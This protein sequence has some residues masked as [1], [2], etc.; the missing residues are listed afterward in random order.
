MSEVRTAR[1]TMWVRHFGTPA[2]AVVALHG[3]T[4]NGDMFADFAGRMVA[5]VAAP[6]LP[7]HGRTAIEPV[8]IGNAVDAIAEVLRGA[9]S[10][11]L[12]LGYSQGGRIALQTALIYP[13]LIGS[14]LL[15]STSPG[16]PERSRRLRRAADEGLADRIEKIGV[17]RFIDEWLANPVTSTSGVDAETRRKDRTTRL[18]NTA[19]GLAAAL[20]GMGQGCVADTSE[21]IPSLTMPTVFLAGEED[22]KYADLAEVMAR[23]RGDRPVLVPGTGHNVVLEAPEAVVATAEDLLS[24]RNG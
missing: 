12:L 5:P 14:L 18:E 19:A 13:D 15:I 8:S 20:R 3:F 11:P 4:L 10:P 24:R 21:K 1:G 2:P 22:D 6:D 23:S 17:E 16:L 9:A 7:G